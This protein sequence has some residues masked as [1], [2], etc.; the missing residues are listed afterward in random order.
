M[1][2]IAIKFDNY[3]MTKML[4][5]KGAN[6][7]HDGGYLLCVACRSGNSAIVQLLL[8][9]G[10]HYCKNIYGSL[11]EDCIYSD[12]IDSLKLLIEFDIV[13][14]I[15]ENYGSVRNKCLE[16]KSKNIIQFI[17]D[18]YPEIVIDIR[19]KKRDIK[20]YNFIKMLI[21]RNIIDVAD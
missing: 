14:M 5:D 16:H 7:N 6:V 1:I 8:N 15:N 4:L 3:Q 12:N 11:V 17:I 20:K 13:N 21:N 2:S 18:H 10:I 9:A 19:I